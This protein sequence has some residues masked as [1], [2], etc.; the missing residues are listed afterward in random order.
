MLHLAHKR[1]FPTTEWIQGI[2]VLVDQ[3]DGEC[4]YDVTDDVEYVCGGDKLGHGSGGIFPA[5][6]GVKLCHL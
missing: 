3:S 1:E 5:A 2:D 6:G 4:V